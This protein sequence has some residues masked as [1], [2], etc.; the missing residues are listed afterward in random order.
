MTT[1]DELNE[2]INEK[3]RQDVNDFHAR[4]LNLSKGVM[5]LFSTLIND[6][7][8]ANSLIQTNDI[9]SSR[10]ALV[11]AAFAQIEGWTFNTKRIALQLNGM[12]S[13][14]LS[15]AEKFLLKDQSFELDDKGD[16]RQMKAKLRLS[17]NV[18]FAFRAVYHTLAQGDSLK[19]DGSGWESFR[20][21]IKVRDRLTH[22]KEVSELEVTD[23]ELKSVQIAL[24]WFGDA[25]L[26]VISSSAER[27]KQLITF[28]ELETKKV[29][30]EELNEEELNSYSRVTKEVRPEYI[31]KMNREIEERVKHIIKLVEREKANQRTNS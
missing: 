1:N 11:R 22:P 14:E 18:R 31:W 13:D 9:P 2:R 17:Q 10:R 28:L 27:T 26:Q 23:E 20:K 15:E 21:S 19:V 4:S 8:E 5:A 30:G 12:F 3:I 6:V 29:N 16:L 7:Q 25:S 24:I